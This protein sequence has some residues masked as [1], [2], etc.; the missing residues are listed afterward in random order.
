IHHQKH[1]G[2]YITNLNNALEGQEAFSDWSIEHLLKNLGQLPEAIHGAVR[3]NGGGHYNHTLFWES[4]TPEGKPMSPAFKEK[5]EAAFGSIDA[6]KAAFKDAGLKRFG[7]GWAWLVLDGQ[8]LKIVSTPNQDAPITDGLKELL[9][10]DV[11]EHAYYLN[12]QNRRADYV[13]AI[14]NV[15]DWEVVES[16]M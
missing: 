6:F 4:L 15:I 16:R 1:H 13:D 14:W 10:V 7:S 5:L 11:W 3:N 12:Y 8:A 2:T 9:G